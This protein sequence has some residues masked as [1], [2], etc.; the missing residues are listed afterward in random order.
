MSMNDLLQEG[1][2][3]KVIPKDYK[4]SINGKVLSIH[5]TFF[6]LDVVNEPSGII[7]N[8]VIEFYSQTRHGTLYF[9]SSVATIDGNKLV[10]LLPSKHRFLQRRAFSRAN[11][12]QES[13]LFA[14]DK[15][16]KIKT[17]DLSAGGL[18]LRTKESLSFGIEYDVEIKINE[19]D[20]IKCK[21][22]PVKIELNEF[23][24]YTVS[25]RFIGLS[26]L[27]RMKIIQFCIRKKVEEENK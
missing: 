25:G 6:L 5:E 3:F 13:A 10:V 19:G 18:K 1:Q 14:G 16:Y 21:F 22:K 15:E 12:A 20:A 17:A 2:I 24:I 9:N 7:P 11:F 8:K 23:D 4:D 27:D 26:G